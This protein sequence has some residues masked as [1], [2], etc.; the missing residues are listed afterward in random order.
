[1]FRY[2]SDEWIAAMDAAVSGDAGLREATV[3]LALA[4]QHHVD[5]VAYVL[6]LDHGRNAVTAGT[7]P[8]ADVTFTCDRATSVAIA[9]GAEQAQS[10][11]MA[12]RLR[13]GGNAQSLLDH[14]DA[15][16]ALDDLTAVVRRETD[17]DDA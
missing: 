9:T 14:Q 11:F 1:M 3:D 10:A 7:D 12:G 5:G 17:F 15:L 6:R 8:T 2:L 16:A 4:V 13:M